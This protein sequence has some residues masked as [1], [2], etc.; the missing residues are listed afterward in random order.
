[1][2]RNSRAFAALA[3]ATLLFAFTLSASATVLSHVGGG[4]Q[5]SSLAHSLNMSAPSPIIY[6]QNPDYNGA[7]SSQNDTTG[8]NGNFATAFDNFTLGS[9]YSIDEVQWVGSYFNPPQQGVITGFTLNFYADAGGAPGALLASYFG[10]GNFGETSLGLDNVGDPVFLYG[11]TLGSA[12]VATG[13]V[14]YWMS[15]VPDLGF[16]PQWGWET[17]VDGDG[18]AYQCFLGPAPPSPR[19]TAFFSGTCSWLYPSFWPSNFPD[20]I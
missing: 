1:M 4:L 9:T 16:P 12:F 3:V 10:N 17:S 20:S 8:G 2:H 13:G 18:L 6:F 5:S 19:C 14:Q 7:F 11:G 15:L